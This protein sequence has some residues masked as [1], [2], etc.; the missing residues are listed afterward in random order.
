M[1]KSPQQNQSQGSQQRQRQG[2]QTTPDTAKHLEPTHSKPP[3][4]GPSKARRREQ[5]DV[6]EDDGQSEGENGGEENFADA[7]ARLAAGPASLEAAGASPSRKAA[8][9]GPKSTRPR[10][11]SSPTTAQ[12]GEQKSAAS[13]D[14]AAHANAQKRG[15]RRA[16]FDDPEGRTAGEGQICFSRYGVGG[17]FKFQGSRSAP[18]LRADEAEPPQPQKIS[19]D[20]PVLAAVRAPDFCFRLKLNVARHVQNDFAK[21]G[22]SDSHCTSV[23]DQVSAF[24]TA[25]Y[26]GR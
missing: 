24:V 13:R 15:E 22:V 10:R 4:D 21:H 14:Q 23:T 20:H 17:T 7:G 26:S 11:A 3:V 25:D 18:R 19:L 8:D 2:S 16:A 1:R 9:R 12:V 5:G 6:L